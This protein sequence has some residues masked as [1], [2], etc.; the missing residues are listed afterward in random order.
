M[1]DNQI[2]SDIV[3]SVDNYTAHVGERYVL[4]KNK[5]YELIEYDGTGWKN[6]RDDIVPKYIFV[7]K[8]M[9]TIIHFNGKIWAQS[10]WF[11]CSECEKITINSLKY[12]HGNREIC[13]HCYFKMNYDNPNMK[14]Y[15]CPPMTLGQYINKFAKVHYHNIN[16]C[17]NKNKCFLCDYKNG[18]ILF[19]IND[20]NLIY[21]GNILNY[22]KNTTIDI[23]I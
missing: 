7:S 20:R 21:N 16:K 15:D 22:V 10:K 13:V 9:R 3:Q 23:V 4:R 12:T 8:Q 14:E 17:P 19:N 1:A 6:I 5:T 2:V 11:I 18:K